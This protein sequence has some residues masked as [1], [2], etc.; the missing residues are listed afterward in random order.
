MAT[1]AQHNH[2]TPDTQHH[3]HTLNPMWALLALPAMVLLLASDAGNN[4]AIV[5]L[6]ASGDLSLWSWQSLALGA[7]IAAA[8]L[9][10]ASGSRRW[11][12]IPCGVV[13][14]IGGLLTV[15]STNTDF[16]DQ[17]ADAGKYTHDYAA[18]NAERLALIESLTPSDGSLPCK[19]QRWCDSQK[20]EARLAQI[21]SMMPTMAVEVD[22]LA[23][24]AGALLAQFIAYLRAFGVPLV[25]AALSYVLGLMIHR[26]NQQTI[27]PN[28]GGGR[29]RKPDTTLREYFA[30]G[31]NLRGTERISPAP[32]TC[33][34]TPQ[35]GHNQHTKTIYLNGL[36]YARQWLMQQPLGR[37]QKSRLQ[38]ASKVKGRETINKIVSQLLS[39]G[40]LVRMGNGQLAKSALPENVVPL[41][42][43][44]AS[45]Q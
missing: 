30:A 45:R 37:I 4:L 44:G 12:I 13:C 7:A 25:V 26:R 27:S 20:K 31:P 2:I 28:G 1:T 11:L 17:S 34:I 8:P 24:P 21:N 29:R 14:L 22:P 18:L 19:H 35:K 23:T 16:A 32:E 38:A 10:Y 9:G 36:K 39:E 42:G 3:P 33:E 6:F 41:T 40:V 15:I 5:H 43:Q